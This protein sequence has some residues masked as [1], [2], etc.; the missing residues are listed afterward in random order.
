MP[1]N[2]DGLGKRLAEDDNRNDPEVSVSGRSA[3][4]YFANDPS[5]AQ[6]LRR[7]GITIRDFILM[8]F[9]S[10][11]GPLTV[12]QLARIVNIE[13]DSL[14]TSIRR[15]AAAELLVR[16]PPAA[17]M[18]SGTEAVVRLTSRGQDIASRINAQL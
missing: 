15:L 12:E 9:L 1:G 13:P 16:E 18:R 2:A 3:A 8:S 17:G 5:V 10:D 14:L 4:L 11:Q 7:H 6:L